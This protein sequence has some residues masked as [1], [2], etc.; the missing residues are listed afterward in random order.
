MVGISV[1]DLLRRQGLDKHSTI[2]KDDLSDAIDTEEYSDENKHYRKADRAMRNQIKL[3]FD[4]IDYIEKYTSKSGTEGS[5]LGQITSTTLEKIAAIDGVEGLSDMDFR[6]M[7]TFTSYQAVEVNHFLSQ[8]GFYANRPITAEG[9]NQAK[10]ELKDTIKPG[11]RFET[12]LTK[13]RDY[14]FLAK[15]EEVA[16]AKGEEKEAQFI[17]GK[18][19]EALAKPM[20]NKRLLE[21]RELEDDPD[22]PVRED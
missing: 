18:D 5:K 7:D 8:Y 11:Q 1:A 4:Q 13:R 2:T 20:R 10:T 17:T 22:P 12:Q 3:Y 19:V 9:L 6:I 15:L 21:V 16:K 14:W